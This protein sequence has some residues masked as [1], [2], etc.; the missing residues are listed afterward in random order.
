ML[1][2]PIGADTVIK[3]IQ[4]AASADIEYQWGA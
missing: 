4:E 2:I 1:V 3:V